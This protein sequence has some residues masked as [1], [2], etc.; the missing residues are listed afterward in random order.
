MYSST[1]ATCDIL[2][3]VACSLILRENCKWQKS[4]YGDDIEQSKRQEWSSTNSHLLYI[5]LTLRP[6]QVKRG[7]FF[8]VW[9]ASSLSLN[10]LS[11]VEAA[12]ALPHWDVSDTV[13]V[14][15]K[16]QIKW[17]GFYLCSSPSPF[18]TF[19]TDKSS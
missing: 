2:W 1:A 5:T 8:W 4:R 17:V 10:K 3:Y 6:K 7:N 19:L 14:L 13:M 9:A 11:S 16:K 18:K 15:Q 12:V